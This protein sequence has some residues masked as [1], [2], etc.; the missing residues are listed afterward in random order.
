VLADQLPELTGDSLDRSCRAIALALKRYSCAALCTISCATVVLPRQERTRR[1]GS[2]HMVVRGDE[3]ASRL[4]NT[5]RA[6]GGYRM[7][8]RD[9]AWSL[10]E[11]MM[12]NGHSGASS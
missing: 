2:P 10:E 12:R 4:Y 6:D 8:F 7:P 3:A 1:P 5:V 9:C 11:R